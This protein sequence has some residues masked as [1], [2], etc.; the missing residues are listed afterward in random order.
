MFCLKAERV[1]KWFEEQC[2]GSEVSTWP[3]SSPDLNQIE[4]VWDVLEADVMD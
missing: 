2:N 4:H 3:P 1:Q